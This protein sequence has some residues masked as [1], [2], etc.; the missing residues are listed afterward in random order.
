MQIAHTSSEKNC[1]PQELGWWYVLSIIAVC[2]SGSPWRRSSQASDLK[3]LCKCNA[4][5]CERD[6]SSSALCGKRIIVS[7]FSPFHYKR[8][9][10]NI[11]IETGKEEEDYSAESKTVNR[12]L[13]TQRFLVFLRYLQ[14]SCCSLQLGAYITLL[15]F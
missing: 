6:S 11:G 15:S 7:F 4:F 10:A 8:F 5:V 3:L 12:F 14:R 9:I 2:G 1:P 13:C